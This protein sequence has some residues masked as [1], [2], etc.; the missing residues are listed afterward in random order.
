MDV[1]AEAYALETYV[2]AAVTVASVVAGE[3]ACR[4]RSSFDC[5]CADTTVVAAMVF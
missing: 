1:G 4:L 5:I 3:V 2:V